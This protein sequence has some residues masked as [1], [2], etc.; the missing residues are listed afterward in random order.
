MPKRYSSLDE[1]IDDLDHKSLLDESLGLFDD[2]DL[3]LL[4]PAIRRQSEAPAKK[5]GRPKKEEYEE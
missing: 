2:E 1:L 5:R 4:Q 3:E